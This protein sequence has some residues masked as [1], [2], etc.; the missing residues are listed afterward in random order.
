MQPTPIAP[1]RE[2]KVPLPAWVDRGEYPFEPKTFATPNGRMSYLDEGV[3]KPVVFVH[4]NPSWSFGWRKTMKPLLSHRR[5]I[6]M[7]HLGFGLSE[8]PPNFSYLPEAQAKNLDALLESLDLQEVTLVVSDW[9]GPVGLS[10]ALA[11]PE[12]IA[13]VVITNT[14]MW[15]V[16]SD[17]Y[18]QGF[19]RFMGGA[20]GRWLIRERNF[21]AS[22]VMRAAFGDKAKLTPAVHGQYLSAL[23][24]KAD[25][26]GCWTFPREIIGSSDWLDSLWQRREVLTKKRVLLAWGMKD[27]AFREKELLR[28]SGALPGARVVRYDDCGHYVAEEHGED[29][30]REIDVLDA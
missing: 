29:L 14:W 6:A 8:K 11:H 3:G 24:D 26:K 2:N 5:C 9:G 7:D 10:Y 1:T 23:Q 15:S 16:K 18:Y 19:S 22:N 17:W 25:R 12:R 28:W 21:F 27:I 30:A 20:L 13:S 4:G